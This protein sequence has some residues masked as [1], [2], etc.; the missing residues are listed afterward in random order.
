[1]ENM[2]KSVCRFLLAGAAL[3]S[4]AGS[5]SAA[6]LSET[7]EGVL[8][9]G[10]VVSGAQVI[11]SYEPLKASGEATPSTERA[12]NKAVIAHFFELPIGE[13]RARLYADDGVKQIPSMGVQWIGLDAQL[14]NNK[15][16]ETLFPG[17]TWAKVVIWDTSDPTVFWVEAEGRTGAGRIPAYSNHYVMQM[18]AKG[19]KIVLFREF[20]TPLTLTK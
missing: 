5:V 2:M 15:Q 13:E 16:N 4:T 19:G 12:A 8:Y 10:N 14:K 6:P 20:G 9:E 1:M 11:H 18:V 17:W 7:P 3:L